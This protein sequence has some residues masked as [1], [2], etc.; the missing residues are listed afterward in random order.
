MLALKEF[1]HELHTLRQNI[2]Q[3]TILCQLLPGSYS[4]CC[5]I[6]VGKICRM[7]RGSG[8]VNWMGVEDL[9]R[10]GKELGNVGGGDLKLNYSRL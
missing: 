4:Q 1:S 7:S 8:Y 3:D 6:L 2:S 10:E 9:H 5:W